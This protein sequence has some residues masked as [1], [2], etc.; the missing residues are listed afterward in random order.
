MAP[1][2]SEENGSRASLGGLSREEYVA[3]VLAITT[4]V[5]AVALA[6]A[7][8]PAAA[9]SL[10]APLVLSL[11]ILG[12]GI[13]NAIVQLS[14]LPLIRIAQ[15]TAPFRVVRT[16]A[17]P[18]LCAGSLGAVLA[19]VTRRWDI[20]DATGVAASA[21]A[22]LILYAAGMLVFYRDR[23]QTIATWSRREAA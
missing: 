8:K 1:G 5:A 11:G 21:G 22:M 9:W 3:H 16:I 14:N 6:L 17:P 7:A 4:R 18:W 12:F 13:A 20:H 15:R 2:I 19:F 23:W 10:A